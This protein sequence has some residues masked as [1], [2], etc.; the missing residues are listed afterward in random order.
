MREELRSLSP[1]AIRAPKFQPIETLEPRRLLSTFTITKGGTYSGNWDNQDS[2][3][4]AIVVKTSQPVT[5]QNSTIKS[6]GDLIVSGVDHTNITVNDVKGYGL[7]PNI[8]GKTNGEFLSLEDFDNVVVIN[9]YIEHVSGG[10]DLQDYAGDRTT[11]EA[12]K[13]AGNIVRNIDGRKSNGKGGYLDY[14][15]RTRK[16]DGKR[17]KGYDYAQFV[18][19]D[20]CS[21]V[22]NI[23]IRWNE[24]INEP[25]KSRV[26]DVI[27]FY[28]SGGTAASPAQIS[29]NYIQ[30]AYTI[31]PWMSDTSDSTY[32][33]DWGFSGGGIMLGD[34][35][36]S[37]G[38]D[39]A[40]VKAFNNTV[41][42]TTNYGI[43][44]AAGHHL[45]AYNNRV[46][47]CGKLPDGRKIAQ[48]NVG[49]YVWDSYKAGSSHFHNNLARD[50][51]VGWMKGSG[52]NDT[53]SPISGAIKNTKKFSGTI[54]ATV[55]T[56]EHSAWLKRFA[57]RPR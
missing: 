34:G 49:I 46:F 17:E 39:P 48:Q 29:D 11:K 47:S 21:K 25:G 41:I 55:E 30:G 56:A 20:N 57:A 45:E 35:V 3:K 31:K 14:N 5:I 8:Y 18:Q 26:E 50:N 1:R 2:A 38:S 37:T 7:N 27:S 6:R 51:T 19:L 44:L 10:V 42:D 36:S 43:A 16:S 24:V 54:T 23:V 12:I 32:T 22:P 53:W 52:R 9:C 4:P 15:E 28:K 13:I 40:Y 33:Y